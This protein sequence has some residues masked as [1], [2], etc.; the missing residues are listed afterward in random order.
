MD[1]GLKDKV[2]M[3]TGGAQGVGRI[4]GHTL[5]KEGANVVIADLNEDGGAKVVKEI[6]DLS[7]KAIFVKCD[8]SKLE[9]TDKLVKAAVD[10]FGSADIMIHNAAVFQLGKFMDST[11]KEWHKVLDVIQVGA[12]N[13]ARSVLPQMMEQKSGKIIFIGTDAAKAGDS[14][15][16][17]YAS[18]KAGV[19][20]F[21]KSL[22]Q[23]VGPKGIN[24][25]AVCPA[26][27]ITE[28]NEALLDQLYGIKSKPE[29][30]KKVLAGYPMRRL[31]VSEDIADMV[32]FIASARADY[33]TGQVI[34]VNGGYSMM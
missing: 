4:M 33:I 17:I 25:N 32:A 3:I 19:L 8:V 7:G 15:Q 34:S 26:V 31:G 6:E 12:F 24:V 5:A 29:K 10:N 9:D 2:T 14:F 16:S 22:A 1:L 13:C 20:N 30:A 27:T 18:A 11:V 23:D 21:T 28:E